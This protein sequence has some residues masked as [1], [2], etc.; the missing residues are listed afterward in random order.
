MNGLMTPFSSTLRDDDDGEAERHGVYE[1][2]VVEGQTPSENS[3]RWLFCSQKYKK[4]QIVYF[5]QIIILFLVIAV[6]LLNLTLPLYINVDTPNKK[7]WMF[8]LAASF[9]ILLPNPK[10][11]KG[12]GR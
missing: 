6:S 5:V 4:T 11:S 7:V 1:P 10:L 8:L 12:D 2:V 9:G 3:S